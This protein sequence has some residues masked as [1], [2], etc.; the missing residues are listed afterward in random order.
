MSTNVG[1][2]SNE[3]EIPRG[4][5]VASAAH[6]VAIVGVGPKGLYCL[7]RLLAE[8][9]A[10]PLLCGLEIHVFNRSSYFGAS[11]VYD[12]EQPEYILV[13]VSV[14]EVDLWSAT[15]PPVA[16]GR[17]LSFVDWYQKEFQPDSPLTG[18]ENL[19]R[20]VVGRY[21]MD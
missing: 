21:L 17:G 16:A 19:S 18:D 20:A 10:R 6:S 4:K 12:P 9:N 3:R 11:P 13:N 8:V 14:G 1:V 2:I 7:E 15:D 5:P